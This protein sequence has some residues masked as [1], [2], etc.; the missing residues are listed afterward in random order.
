MN[1]TQLAIAL[2][3][4]TALIGCDTDVQE[5]TRRA[6][7]QEANRDAM[8][9]MNVERHELQ[10]FVAQLKKDDPKIK[11]AY[12]TVDKETGQRVLNI[13]RE[14]DS[15]PSSSGGA[16]AGSLIA[17]SMLG[18][19][20]GNSLS[21]ALTSGSG[22]AH[23]SLT[24][25]ST[26]TTTRTAAQER[27]FRSTGQAAYT[28]AQK[29]AAVARVKADPARMKTIRTGAMSRVSSARSASYSGSRGA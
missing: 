21:N 16:G 14:D 9:R 17:Y 24:S 29:K 3:A 2:A 15:K 25:H 18:A 6:L 26:S 10:S 23:Q 22:S 7:E 5:E 20:A 11:D 19:M 4:A 27:T 8:T 13:V 28:G 12:Y 1:K